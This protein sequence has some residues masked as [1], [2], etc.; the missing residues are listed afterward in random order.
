VDGLS[1]HVLGAFEVEGVGAA[2]LG[3]RKARTLLKV[4]ALARGQ[5]VSVDRLT[6]VLWAKNRRPARPTRCP[7][8]SAGSGAPSALTA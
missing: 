7:S 3:R 5:P 6:E 1:I 8:S 2:G 4:L